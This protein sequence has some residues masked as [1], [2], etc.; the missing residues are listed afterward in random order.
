LQA[1]G[2]TKGITYSK[3]ARITEQSQKGIEGYYKSGCYS[4]REFLKHN[5]SIYPQESQAMKK[6]KEIENESGITVSNHPVN[7]AMTEKKTLFYFEVSR[8]RIPRMEEYI[9]C[10]PESTK[11]QKMLKT[12]ATELLNALKEMAISPEIIMCH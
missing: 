11:R 5:N 2:R 12:Q 3:R 10:L 1:T 9:N 8:I 4:R 7:I 6:A